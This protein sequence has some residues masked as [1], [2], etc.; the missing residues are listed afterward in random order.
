M[1]NERIVSTFIYY[2]QSEN[3]SESRL[4]FSQATQ[5]PHYHGQDDSYCMQVLYGMGR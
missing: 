3:I 4:A 5:E 1:D 2:Y